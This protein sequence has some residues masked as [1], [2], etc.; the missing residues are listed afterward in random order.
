VAHGGGTAARRPTAAGI[1]WSRLVR[2]GLLYWVGMVP[3]VWTFWLGLTDQLGPDPMKV[4][5]RSLGLWALRFLVVGL[6]ITPLRRL[7][8]INLLRYRRAIGLLAF[9][10][11]VLHLIT[12]TVLDQGLDWAAIWKD[13]VKRPYITIGMVAF[14]VLVP[15]AATSNKA[16]I[17]RLGGP[18]WVRLHKWVYL[19]AAAAA[20]HFVL[21]V[22]AWPPEPL[23][24][25]ALV[26]V[27][28]GYRLVMRL[29]RP[30]AR[31][32]PPL[33]TGRRPQARA[34]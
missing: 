2:P 32:G 23:V 13:I 5:E 34:V 25:A 15:L 33:G 30:Q 4:L 20:V 31:S 17:R 24:Y 7:F 10:Y 29:R 6:T 14:L 11:A 8:N 26:T 16:A 3:A 27:L 22:K 1:P 18:A 9:F 19:A 21:V 12:Y 28:L